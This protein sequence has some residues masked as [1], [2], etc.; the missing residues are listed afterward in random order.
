MQDLWNFKQNPFM[1]LISSIFSKN[2]QRFYG[3]VRNLHSAYTDPNS[4]WS[5][6]VGG[7]GLNNY[8]AYMPMLRLLHNVRGTVSGDP[9]FKPIYYLG[10]VSR[11][12]GIAGKQLLLC[13]DS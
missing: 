12:M 1:W 4:D 3:A 9:N 8:S 6:Y 11:G 7:M 5:R 13:F 10:S 2:P